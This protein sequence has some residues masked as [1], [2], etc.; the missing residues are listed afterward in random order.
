MRCASGAGMARTLRFISLTCAALVLGLTLAHVLEA[1]GKRQLNGAEWTVVQNMFYGGFA[2]VGGI[3]EVLGLLSSAALAAVVRRRRNL[4]VLPG[5]AAVLFLGTL[6]G[7]AFGNRPINDQVATWNAT[8]LRP[9]WAVYRD[10]WDAAHALSAALAAVAF[11]TLL[12][13]TRSDSQAARIHAAAQAKPRLPDA[14]RGED[15]DAVS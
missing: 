1:P 4:C 14:T 9:D 8:T 10:R 15:G 2:V 5:L 13:S 7:F 6:L 3:G 11:L 12:I